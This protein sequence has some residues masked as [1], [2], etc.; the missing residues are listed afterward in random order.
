MKRGIYLT[1]IFLF[2]ILL[3]YSEE[4]VLFFQNFDKIT[5]KELVDKK[6]VEIPKYNH[7]KIEKG[8]LVQAQPKYYSGKVIIGNKN[9]RITKIEFD[10]KRI[11]RG[12]KTKYGYDNHTGVRIWG[13]TIWARWKSLGWI[14][15]I[16][17]SGNK[18]TKAES[19]KADFEFN[20]WYHFVA[21]R[22]EKGKVKIYINGNLFVTIPYS[23]KK[24]GPVEFY[25]YRI[26]SGF[27]NIKIYGEEITSEENEKVEMNYNYVPNS[28]FEYTTNY[29]MPDFWS[30]YGSIFHWGLHS[31]EWTTEKGYKKWQQMFSVDRKNSFDGKN[32]LKV[33]YPVGLCST[34]FNVTGG[35]NYVF[36]VYLKSDRDK[37][38]V[39][40]IVF[41]PYRKKISEKVVSAEKN[42]KRFSLKI[43]IPEVSKVYV[44]FLPQE[45]G[46]LWIDAVQL[47]IG[48]KLTSYNPSPRDEGLFKKK[49]ENIGNIVKEIP[50]TSIEKRIVNLPVID[51]KIDDL[52]WKTLPVCSL[53]QMN[54]KS[55]KIKTEFKVAY[56][57]NYIYIGV[58]CYAKEKGKY[59]IIAGKWERDS[60][61]V[62]GE[63]SIEIF[64]TPEENPVEYFHMAINAMNSKFDQKCKLGKGNDL[65]WNGDWKSA[66]FIGENFWSIEV[67]IPFEDFIKE[68][69]NVG[70]V[71]RINICR[72]YP[73]SGELL[74]WSPTLTGF[75]VPDRFGYLY[76]GFSPIGVSVEDL[77]LIWKNPVEKEM[78]FS[79]KNREK[80][81]L[82]LEIRLL[83][84]PEKKKYL[85]QIAINPEEKKKVN[86]NILSQKPKFKGSIDIVE[87]ETGNLV[88]SKEIDLKAPL[89]LKTYFELSYYTSEEKAK[90]Y[91]D[92]N[93][94]DDFLRFASLNAKN[95]K[96]RL[97]KRIKPHKGKNIIEIPLRK[98][99]QGESK[100]IVELREKKKILRKEEVE[101]L[102]LSPNNI[103]VKIDRTKDTILVNGKPLFPFSLLWEGIPEEETVK[104]IADSGFKVF[105]FVWRPGNKP[106]EV[107]RILK[108]AEE[109]NLLIAA[110]PSAS[111][112]H[113]TEKGLRWKIEQIN[114]FKDSPIIIAW[115]VFDEPGKEEILQRMVDEVK[116]ADPYRIAWTNYNSFGLKLR[117]GGMPGEIISLDRYPIP[118]ED[119]HTVENTAKE[120]YE[121]SSKRKN[122]LWYFLQGGGYAHS[123]WRSPTPEEEEY[124]TYIA[125][126]E[127]VRGIYY[128]SGI[129]K[130][131]FLWERVK[132]LNREIQTLSPIL[133]SNHKILSVKVNNPSIRFITMKHDNK[134]YIIS[135]NRNPEKEIVEFD[136]STLNLKDKTANVLFENR[137]VILE[138]SK[139][140]DTFKGY[141]RHVY[142]IKG[143]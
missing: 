130:S 104:Y 122:P 124:M 87:K 105:T 41:Y 18:P 92:V 58:K 139:L 5:L 116:K 22:D 43:K 102:K 26:K 3:G 72:N 47:E 39:K 106:E 8:A 55:T 135:V 112:M 109:N 28:S 131:A 75:H 2:L 30:S 115:N 60:F 64:I 27:D 33:V 103:E 125:V 40:M 21:E 6:I 136:L 16:P 23:P 69:M 80:R 73:Q 107:E 52:C 20:K 93:F 77:T 34:F 68:K 134:Y 53:R 67:A 37:Y 95:E 118:R 74:S 113:L 96:G 7:W 114:K 50:S 132:Q 76:L 32:S 4:K 99:P 13:L 45:K 61:K 98:I 42:W 54:G 38:P 133:F 89:P 128:F 85:K 86:F 65:K 127:G 97:I 141:Q 119:I 101:L 31:G 35:N 9:W 10:F 25:T 110:W 120:M 90:L 46:I 24:T 56:D 51:G 78:S 88:Y 142:E 137:N 129:P 82:N 117:V 36:S 91:V 15:H 1:V 48:D 100:I 83:S 14:G 29:D 111:G 17:P 12:M 19:K 49:K 126:I 66:T 11:E 123:M 94:P 59:K 63:D 138:G 79:V 81:K 62:F 143:E 71:F 84:F 108:V 121:I 44:A 140:K 70:K 57:K